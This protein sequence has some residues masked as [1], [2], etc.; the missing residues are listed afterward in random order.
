MKNE[1][2]KMSQTFEIEKSAPLV[3]FQI[4]PKCLSIKT[5]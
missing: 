3:N 5:L 2:M 4:A 1:F